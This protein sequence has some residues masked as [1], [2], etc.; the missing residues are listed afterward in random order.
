MIKALKNF[1]TFTLASEFYNEC[2]KV[3]LDPN[4]HDQ[5]RRATQGILLTLGEGSAK[6]SAK[7]RARY[8][9]MALGS[10]RESQVILS[11]AN[12]DDLLTRFDLLGTCLFKLS[13]SGK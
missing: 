3:K 1:R 13:R 10:F 7:D 6:P 5:L 8:Y 2:K 4:L 11:L 12:R 9:A